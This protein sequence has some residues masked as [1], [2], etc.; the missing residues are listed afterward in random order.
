[1][2]LTSMF[3]S[4]TYI[5]FLILFLLTGFSSGA[6]EQELG[7]SKALLQ[8]GFTFK[9]PAAAFPR[10]KKYEISFSAT[11]YSASL[12]AIELQGLP[13]SNPKASGYYVA[14]WQGTQIED[15]YRS[16]AQQ[17]IQLDSQEGSFVFE[18]SEGINN[19]DYIIGLGIDDK[20]STSFCSTVIIPKDQPLYIPVSDTY[21]F[22][23]SVTLVK[24][25]TNSLIAAYRTPAFN[26][27]AMN[28]NWIALFQGPFT[29]NTF[30][31]R[32]L[33]IRQNIPGNINEGM[34]AINNIEGGLMPEQYY[35]LVY[36]MGYASTDSNSTYNIIAATE[37]QV[38][39]NKE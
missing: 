33:I 21:A 29:A 14:L 39:G 3:L 34:A 26:L 15:R 6:P 31:G 5:S 27:P 37:F 23:S 30:K 1:M 7:Y 18:L 19:K 4:K 22:S 25:G 11:L 12:I 16:Q 28:Q 24:I 2:V 38:P 20:D 10:Q 13:G 35:T 8:E 36:G 17:L 9:G 32:N